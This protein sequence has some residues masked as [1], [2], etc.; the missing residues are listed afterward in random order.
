MSDMMYCNIEKNLFVL[1][2]NKRDIYETDELKSKHFAV[3]VKKSE[4]QLK[5]LVYFIRTLDTP[6]LPIH[7]EKICVRDTGYL[8]GSTQFLE[9]KV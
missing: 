8:L 3:M 4:M 6:L 5:K 2:T 1:N 7:M 9:T